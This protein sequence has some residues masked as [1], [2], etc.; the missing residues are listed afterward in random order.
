MTE[1]ALLLHF[2]YPTYGP[3]EIF[4]DICQ[5]CYEKLL[6]MLKE[7]EN[8]FS[9][10]RITVNITGALLK[11]FERRRGDLFSLI[12]ELV[13]SQVL[14]LMASPFHQAPAIF[15]PDGLLKEQIYHHLK[16]IYDCYGITPK[17]FFPPELIFAKDILPI[18]SELGLNYVV[19]DGDPIA[20]GNDNQDLGGIY[21]CE[22]YGT[23]MK[24]FPRNRA[25]S[26]A[27]SHGWPRAEQILDMATHWKHLSPV[28]IALDAETFGY[29]RSDVYFSLLWH[30][31]EKESQRTDISIWHANDLLNKS[32]VVGSYT[33]D[34]ITTWAED[35]SIFFA[36]SFFHKMWIIRNEVLTR[37]RCVELLYFKLEN[38][39]K[40]K[41]PIYNADSL[42]QQLVAIKLNQIDKYRW[43]IYRR[44][45]DIGLFHKKYSNAHTRDVFYQDC[46]KIRYEL[47]W[48][49]RQLDDLWTSLQL[50]VSYGHKK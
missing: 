28:L 34:G 22:F 10:V 42:F 49:E 18:L 35:I 25:L 38:F 36:D 5:K 46:E 3:D 19:V 2:H 44:L 27:L 1:I 21:N 37:Y 31:F 29:Y 16:M 17:G 50:D 15:T 13:D 11:W 12:G 45:L 48:V 8:K 43:L 14:E 6:Y 30:L 4:E 24:L 7:L 20:F 23:E 41:K 39:I 33:F 9:P 47:G 32:S 40:Q 26:Y